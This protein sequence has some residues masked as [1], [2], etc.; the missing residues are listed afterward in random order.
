ME[1]RETALRD[2]NANNGALL[3]ELRDVD[4][5]RLTEVFLGTWSAREILAHL[6]AWYDMMGQSLERMG[7][8]ERPSPEGTDLNDTEGMNARFVAQAQGQTV[9]AVRKQLEIGLARLEAAARVLPDDR[10]QAGK[11]AL[12]ILQAMAEHPIEHIDEVRAWKQRGSKG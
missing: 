5:E 4:D 7:R 9:A 1:P 10:F 8:G 3:S 12:R 2:L 11:T 6:G